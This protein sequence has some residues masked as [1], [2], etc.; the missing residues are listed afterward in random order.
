MTVATV[1]S[2]AHKVR[3]APAE[4]DLIQG[5][6]DWDLHLP[7]TAVDAKDADTPDA[8]IPRDPRIQRLT[9]RHPLNCEPPMD[10]LM[11]SGFITPPSIHYVRNHGAV[12]RI[13]WANHRIQV[14]GLVDSPLTITM[15]EL[16]DMPS[17]TLPVS[18]TL[19]LT[20]VISTIHLSQPPCICNADSSCPLSSHFNAIAPRSCQPL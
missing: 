19:P 7:A 13:D 16:I 11:A 8:W 4:P 18:L 3:G 14:N 6:P 10:V 15:D 12:P 17:V 1:Q 5:T 9:G 20:I 2:M